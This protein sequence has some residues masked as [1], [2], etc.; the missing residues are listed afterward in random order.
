[1]KVLNIKTI[2][3]SKS[4]ALVAHDNRKPALVSWVRKH[5]IELSKHKLFGTGTT[6]KLIQKECQLPVTCFA[7]GPWGG[8]LQIGA[9]I[10]ESKIDF[11]IF[12]W[13]PLTAQPHDPDVKAL[14]RLSVAWNIPV[15]CNSSTADF[16]LTSPLMT[17]EYVSE[18]FFPPK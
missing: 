18:A 4:I 10:V 12:F 14:I 16:I 5:K 6:G 17:E 2:P 9:A 13:D 3:A 15:A 7:S 1:M 11:L 8:D